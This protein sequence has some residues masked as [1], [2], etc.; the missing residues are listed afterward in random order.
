MTYVNFTDD[1]TK[2]LTIDF[3]FHYVKPVWVTDDL[4][5]GWY[6][7]ASPQSPITN[8]SLER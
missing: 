4:V 1:D 6:Q 7:A 3:L 5:S 2:K 8:N